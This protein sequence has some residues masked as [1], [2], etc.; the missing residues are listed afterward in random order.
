MGCL[1]GTAY[2]EVADADDGKRKRVRF[3]NAHVK[4]DIPHLDR[5]T[6]K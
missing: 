6:V 1:S 3:E 4:K 5:Y 2:C